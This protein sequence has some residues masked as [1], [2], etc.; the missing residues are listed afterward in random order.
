M[1]NYVIKRIITT[2]IRRYSLL[3]YCKYLRKQK[4]KSEKRTALTGWPIIGSDKTK[5]LARFRH[6]FLHHCLVTELQPKLAISLVGLL[7]DEVYLI[8]VIATLN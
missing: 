8:S 4:R 7:I 1:I 5:K 6:L 2:F 3:C